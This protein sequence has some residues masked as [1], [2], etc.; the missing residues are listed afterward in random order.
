MTGLNCAW[1]VWLVLA[2]A[3]WCWLFV[4]GVDWFRLVLAGAGWF[5]LLFFG[6]GRFRF[7]LAGFGRFRYFCVGLGW[8]SC[9]VGRVSLLMNKG[10]F[11]WVSASVG[12]L[13]RYLLARLLCFCLFSRGVGWFWLVLLDVDVVVDFRGNGELRLALVIL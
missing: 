2:G 1:Y 10:W 11:W 9:G 6:V 3:G 8:F 5:W 7:V 4:V 13:L 12:W